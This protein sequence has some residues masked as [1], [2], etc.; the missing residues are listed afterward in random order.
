MSKKTQKDREINQDRIWSYIQN[1]AAES[2]SGA[3]PRL[4]FLVRQ[5]NRKTV[6]PCPCVLNIGAGDGYLE[7][8]IQQRGWSSYALDPDESTIRRLIKEGIKGYR[9]YVEEMPFVDEKFDFVIA[10]E[11]LEHLTDEERHQGIREISRVLKPG[12]WFIGTVP[13]RE[14][15]SAN[16]VVCPK[17]GEIFHRWGHK[18]SFDLRAIGDELAVLLYVSDIRRT[19]FVSFRERG[20]FEKIRGIFRVIMAKAGMEIAIPSIYFAAKKP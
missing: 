4:D 19:A 14:N 3:K 17:C 18:K 1:Y 10:S 9:G 12:G 20:F 16:E 2:F 6:S 7:R 15:L 13:Y 5:M 8:V 11:V